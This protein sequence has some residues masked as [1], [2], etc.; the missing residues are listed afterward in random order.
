MIELNAKS[1]L[2]YFTFSYYIVMNFLQHLFSTL[3]IYQRDDKTKRY[4]LLFYVT[5]TK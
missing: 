3:Y 4:D 1:I 2:V 5:Y